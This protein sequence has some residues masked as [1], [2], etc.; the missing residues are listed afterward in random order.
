VAPVAQHAF[1]MVLLQHP[2]QGLELLQHAMIKG[3]PA[4]D[5]MT[6]VELESL[7]DL[8]C[9]EDVTELFQGMLPSLP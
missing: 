3:I 2:T 8:N 7:S 4:S 5:V 1:T 6:R 9:W